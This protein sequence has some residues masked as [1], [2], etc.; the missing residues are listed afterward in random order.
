VLRARFYRLIG[1][2]LSFTAMQEHPVSSRHPDLTPGIGHNGGPVL[3]AA[4]AQSRDT[5][6]TYT[7][8]ASHPHDLTIKYLR[9]KEAC[10]YAS[11][12][13]SQLYEYLK[14]GRVRARK[15][16]ATTLIEVKSLDELA[17]SLPLYRSASKRVSGG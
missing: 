13:R 6:A 8:A 14:A 7:A 15:R 11:I 16:G 1:S 2:L 4:A 9:V 10:R 3:D 17:D 12:G 5:Y